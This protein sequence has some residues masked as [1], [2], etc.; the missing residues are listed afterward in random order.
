VLAGS[1]VC[2]PLVEHHGVRKQKEYAYVCGC[3]SPSL[4]IPSGSLDS[5]FGIVLSP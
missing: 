4:F 2:R 3:S 1:I 5:T